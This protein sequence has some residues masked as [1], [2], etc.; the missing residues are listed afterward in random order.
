MR[1]LYRYGDTEFEKIILNNDSRSDVVATFA[2]ILELVKFQ[3]VFLGGDYDNPTL[4]LNRSH[5]TRGEKREA[6][7]WS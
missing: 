1:Y 2:A 7:A 4:V 3:R 6:D 5:S